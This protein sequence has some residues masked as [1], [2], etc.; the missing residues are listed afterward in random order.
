V[1]IE[2][3]YGQILGVHIFGA[4]ATEMI[5]EPA[6]LM[7]MEV[8]AHEVSDA[9]IHGHPTYGEAFMEACSDALGRCIHLPKR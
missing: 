2:K 7:S 1:I 3:N 5:A 8:T 6:A 9:I 4:A